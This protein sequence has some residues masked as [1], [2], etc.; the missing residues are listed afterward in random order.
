MRK[1]AYISIQDERQKVTFRDSKPKLI[2]MILGPIPVTLFVP[3]N[4]D[5]NAR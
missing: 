5:E 1:Y 3:I 4:K 2:L